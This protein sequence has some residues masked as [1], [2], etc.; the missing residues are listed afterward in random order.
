MHRDAILETE[1]TH[2]A[3]HSG[4]LSGQLVTDAVQGLQIDLLG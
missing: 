1:S 4:S 3:D 2:L